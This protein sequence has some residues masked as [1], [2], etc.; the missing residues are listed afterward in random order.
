MQKSQL[1]L[2]WHQQGNIKDARILKAFEKVP[3]DLYVPREYQQQAYEDS[4]LPLG[5]GAT[6]SQPTTIMLML[7]AL[8]IRPGNKILEIGTGSG[9]NA[10]LLAELTGKKGKVITI[11]FIKELAESAAKKLQQ[12]KN[13]KVIYADGKYGYQKEAPYH[14][15]IA[16]AACQEIPDALIK[17]LKLNGILII[18]IGPFHNQEVIKITKLKTE[19]KRES[20]GGFVFVP[21]R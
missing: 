12:Y 20:L 13:I 17:Q 4:P 1:L 2:I 15:I 21:M 7:Q 16:T 18:P 11:E 6:I 14:R 19:L 9:Y 3:R 5:H 10:A 8:N